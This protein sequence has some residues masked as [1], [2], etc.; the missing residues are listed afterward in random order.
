MAF[1]ALTID[2]NARLAKFEDDMARVRKS[3]GGLEKSAGVLKAGLG[4][5]FAGV[6][7]AGLA[8]FAKNGIDAADAL[9]DMSERLG[10]SV[11]D[12]ASFK[13]A[14]EQSGTELEGVGKG[15]AK[16]T[17]SIGEAEGG[18]AKL[19]EALK[20]LGISARDPKEAFFQLADATEKIQD[21][22]KRAA[23]LSQV[24]GKSYQ[25]LVPLLSQGS[26]E[27]RKSA[28][29][30]ETFAEAMGRLAP[31]ADKFNDN[32][33][34]LKS[35]AAGFAATLLG[36][37]VQAMNR[38]TT[39]FSEGIRLA[40]GFGKALMLFGSINPFK[41]T[42][43]NLEAL[44]KRFS[45]IDQQMNRAKE[46]GNKRTLENLQSERADV[47]KKI[48]YL[49]AVKKAGEPVQEKKK[50]TPGE[51]N[52]PAEK[53]AKTKAAKSSKAS[54]ADPLASLLGQTDIVKM[55]EFEKTV[56]LLNARFD[57]GKKNADLYQ[58][59]MKK[60]V[61]TTFS[62]RFRQAADDQ[63]FM[64]EVLQDGINTINES[65]ERTRQWKESVAEAQEELINLISP[66]NTLIKQLTELDKFDGFIDPEILAE[67]R[68]QI[69]AQIDE[70]DKLP[71]KAT[72]IKDVFSGAFSQM[73]S[74][75]A[76]FATTGKLNF[77][78]LISAMLASVAQAM[79]NKAF[80]QF[81]DSFNNKNGG[82]KSGGGGF[83][84]G[85]LISGLFSGI[86]KSAK[87]NVFNSPGL[88]AYSGQIVSKPTV[89]PFA[90]G[91]GLMGEAG[92]EAILPLKRGKDGKLG[93]GLS[94][95]GDGG[96]PI[97]S[98]SVDATGSKVEGDQG[99]S[100]EFGRMIG[101]AVRGVLIQEMRPGGM[102][103]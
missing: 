83:D 34:L 60:L 88:S 75:I 70:M 37:V 54:T 100:G 26:E 41:S 28:I 64:N 25:D 43:D 24:L 21:P 42:G 18:N 47:I 96:G 56:A 45:V 93:V 59:A 31:D 101:N 13:L 52:L 94:G 95:G 38:L 12:L 36:P 99:K 46:S 8:A 92:A 81:M 55:Q 91:I 62:D 57:G 50:F 67:A 30:S 44:G 82:G 90:K 78:S 84:W 27:L 85:G 16:L 53:P 17:R 68:L 72:E 73:S 80:Q 87:G 103:A 58:Q 2:L 65:N 19:G 23:L 11:K 51:I 7:V 71:A 9:K 48:Q 102:L 79:A 33:E 66:V 32:L 61:E 3:M 77:K 49:T 14:A 29:S 63:A 35:R 20:A 4:G 97:I 10:V 15:I 98:V 76:E 22:A 86:V 89:F 69:N 1:A 6:G 5:L 39:E 40:G 74:A